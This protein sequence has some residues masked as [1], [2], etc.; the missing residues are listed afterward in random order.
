MSGIGVAEN[1]DDQAFINPMQTQFASYWGSRRDM[2]FCHRYSAYTSHIFWRG[3]LL[4]VVFA[5]PSVGRARR[6]GC[7]LSLP[8]ASVLALDLDTNG[9]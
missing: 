6:Y 9:A 1:S 8:E 2:I 5:V 3:L 4:L 7:L